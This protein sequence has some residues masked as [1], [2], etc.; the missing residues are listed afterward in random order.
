MQFGVGNVLYQGEDC[1][2]R[3]DT[4]L[5]Y[6]YFRHHHLRSCNAEVIIQQ[7]KL[8]PLIIS[9]K[10]TKIISTSF[11][12]SLTKPQRRMT[13]NNGKAALTEVPH[14]GVLCV[15][16]TVCIYQMIKKHA[17]TFLFSFKNW[18]TFFWEVFVVHISSC[19][20]CCTH[21]SWLFFERAI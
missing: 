16:V 1:L 14:V 3:V 15:H 6:I 2:K 8:L 20:V 17:G 21:L 13:E 10:D 7:E 11:L 9:R 5:W 19:H 4:L 18:L 12:R